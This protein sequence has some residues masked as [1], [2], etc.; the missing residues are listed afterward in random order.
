M[1]FRRG[2]V[3][4]GQGS[5]RVRGEE[6]RAPR[7]RRRAGHEPQETEPREPARCA[8]LRIAL[9]GMVRDEADRTHVAT[10][11]SRAIRVHVVKPIRVSRVRKEATVMIEPTLTRDD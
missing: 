6:D 2:R 5:L 8:L 1:T 9:T 7:E 3:R 11:G 4:G 10:N